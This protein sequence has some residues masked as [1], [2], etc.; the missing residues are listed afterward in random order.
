MLKRSSCGDLALNYLV[1]AMAVVL[2][3]V[4]VI[5]QGNQAVFLI[6]NSLGPRTGDALW[7]HW[8][9]LGD[10]LVL[11]ALILPFVGRRPALVWSLLVTA[12]LAGLTVSL[13]K[14]FLPMPRPPAV[15][16]SDLIHVIGPAYQSRSFPS[17][18]TVAAFAFAG[19]LSLHFRR[20]W[21]MVL[22]LGLAAGVGISRMAVGV[23]WPMDVAAG[24][25]L[26]WLCAVAGGHLAGRWRWGESLIGQ[27][28]A[29]V[30][31]I[32]AALGLLLVFRP[33]SPQA[34]YMPK[35]I[36][37]MVLMVSMPGFIRLWR[38]RQ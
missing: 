36:A 1:P 22:V 5:T 3:L 12:L 35:G 7:A 20:V 13:F 18:H 26:G 14:Q 15:L 25:G 6:F 37:V 32:L 38:G 19:A 8:T 11:S 10:G 31:L 33:D 16:A 21:F 28:V 30:L 27:R 4:I 24:A 9:L 17:G 23:H 29:A 2:A 34:E